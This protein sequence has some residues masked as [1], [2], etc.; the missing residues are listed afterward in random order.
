MLNSLGGGSYTSRSS[1]RISVAVAI[2]M[3]RPLVIS[4][5]ITR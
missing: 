2:F 1:A 5:N 4:E 3:Y